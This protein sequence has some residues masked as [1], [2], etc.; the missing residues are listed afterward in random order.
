MKILFL[1]DNL[2]KGGRE[3]RIIELIKSLLKEPDMEIELVIFKNAITYPEIHNLDIKLHVIERKPK[4]NPLVFRKLYKICKK[5]QPDVIHSWSSM[6]SLFAFPTVKFEN[7]PLLN[8]SIANAPKGLKFWQKKSFWA[9][10]AFLFSDIVVGNSE[11]GLRVY[12]APK[13]K[14][15]CIYNGYDFNRSKKIVPKER[16][17]A[18]YGLENEIVVGK[19][20]AFANRKDYK[21]Y[22]EA[23]G[24]VLTT[25]PNA[26]FFAVGDGP[27]FERIKNSVPSEIK[28]KI[29]FTGNIRDVESLINI[30]DIG[31]LSTNSDVHGEGISNSILEYMALGKP[32]VA[33]EGGGTNEI[34]QDNQTGFLVPNKSPKIMA[35]QILHLIEHPEKSKTMGDKGRN[36][37]LEHFTIEKMTATYF[38]LY[39]QLIIDKNR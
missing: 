39:K 35:N 27:D 20:A 10:V 1:S 8:S 36:R 30:F 22:I 25:K 28:D 9:K 33:T 32:V 12:D 16:V 17:I 11:A 6:T 15:L 2:I 38:G 14:R 26:T 21:T 4:L 3:R 18:K 7:I 23:A 34:I 29:I 24:L 5:A 37:I 31:V 19:I 13:N